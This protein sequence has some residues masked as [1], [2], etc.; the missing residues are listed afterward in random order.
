MQYVDNS[1][2]LAGI[3]DEL[4]VRAAKYDARATVE[5]IFKGEVLF[6]E[7]E[8]EGAAV[9]YFL[10]RKHA[11]DPKNN[12]M[13]VLARVYR[14]PGNKLDEYLDRMREVFLEPFYE[15]VDEHIDDQ[16]AILYF[17]RRYKHRCEW[18]QA[19][20]LRKLLEDDTQRGERTLAFDLYEFLHGQ[21]ID[22]HIEPESASGIADF[23]ADQVGDDRVVAD[24]KIFGP[25]NR[26]E[27]LISS[28]RSIKPTP[29]PVTTTSHVPIWSFTRCAR[30]TCIS[31][32]RP[33]TRCFHAFR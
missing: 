11:E 1:P 22:F 13:S 24:A 3:R 10:L 15:Y 19:D 21:G 7:T 32:F 30:K 6:G 26:K 2:I 23:V 9:G 14:L 17:L 18:F 5:R 16:Q 28:R 33:L 12:S 8:E 29:T 20:R 25:R 27:S 31:S 4:L